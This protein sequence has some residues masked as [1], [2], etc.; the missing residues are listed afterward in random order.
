MDPHRDPRTD[1]VVDLLHRRHRLSPD[2]ALAM[3]SGAARRKGVG[4]GDIVAA[5]L[6]QTPLPA[7]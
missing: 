7:R 6:G 5:I 2:R 1:L 3:L 4:L